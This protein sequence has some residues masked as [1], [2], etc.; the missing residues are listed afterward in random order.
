MASI[1]T[2][3]SVLDGGLKGGRWCW[4]HD[5]NNQALTDQFDPGAKDYLESLSPVRMQLRTNCRN[6]QV[7]L[8]WIQ[9][10]LDADLGVHGAG[11]GPEVRMQTAADK[12]ESAERIERETAELIDVGGLAPGSITISVAGR[13]LCIFRRRHVPGGC[14]P[15]PAPGRILN[16]GFAQG[17]GRIRQDRGVQRSGERCDYRRGSSSTDQGGAQIDCPLCGC[18]P[19]ALRTV[20]DLPRITSS[21]QH[22]ELRN[23]RR[24]RLF[25]PYEDRHLF[26][27]VVQHIAA[28]QRVEAPLR[29][30]VAADAGGEVG[31]GHGSPAAERP[32][33]VTPCATMP[34]MR[35][36]RHRR[37]L[38]ARCP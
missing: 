21:I 26:F 16:A 18:E 8:E 28:L 12:R 17:Q 31:A 14:L 9:N 20:T 38:S 3:D 23:E 37:A 15:H 27:L 32:V 11:A 36:P 13:V 4:L 24:Q 6:T 5:L 29:K 19:C 7:I 34:P 35:R 2:L 22:D 25:P 30:L 1:D 10:S 33:E